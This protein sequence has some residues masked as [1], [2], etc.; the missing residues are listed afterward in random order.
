M[1]R[2]DLTNDERLAD[3]VDGRLGEAELERLEAE[4][5]VDPRFRDAAEK[6]RRS[7]ESMRAA[8]LGERVPAGLADRIAARIEEESEVRRI[9]WLPIAGSLLAA[10]ALVMVFFVVQGGVTPER[11]SPDRV[12]AGSEDVEIAHDRRA[13]RAVEG[14]AIERRPAEEPSATADFDASALSSVEEEAASK[15]PPDPAD[16]AE[17]AQAVRHFLDALGDAAVVEERETEAVPTDEAS[18]MKRARVGRVEKGVEAEQLDEAPSGGWAP[19]LPETAVTAA[20]TTPTWQQDV[21]VVLELP[22]SMAGEQP[23]IDVRREQDSFFLGL[24]EEDAAE[25]AAKAA[26][27]APAADTRSTRLSIDELQ[28]E[29]PWARAS[30]GLLREAFRTVSATVDAPQPVVLYASSSS[31]VRGTEPGVASFTLGRDAFGYFEPQVNDLAFEFVGPTAP[32]VSMVRELSQ[33]SRDLGGTVR[34]ERTPP[35]IGPVA[36]GGGGKLEPPARRG[37]DEPR[38]RTWIVVRPSAAPKVERESAAEEPR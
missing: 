16:D 37:D 32:M 25:D 14:Q 13:G 4:F 38:P 35:V 28:P 3:W 20:P 5:R 22:A 6:Y 9:R 33:R 31:V 29:D 8:L 7:V 1:T 27:D 2:R 11:A 18:E 10:A 30:V 23:E 17:S 15:S 12:A 36:G 19:A 21:V 34:V 24:A 26:P